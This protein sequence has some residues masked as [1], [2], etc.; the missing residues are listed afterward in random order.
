MAVVVG[1]G[2]R[3]AVVAVGKRLAAVEMRKRMAAAVEWRVLS[4]NLMLVS[5]GN[6]WNMAS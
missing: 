3:L 2:K 4:Q 6:Y 1:V 5:Q